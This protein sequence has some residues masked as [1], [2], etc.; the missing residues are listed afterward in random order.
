MVESQNVEWKRSWKDK[1][2]EWVCGF[3]NAQGGTI[4]IG[5]D[6]DGAVHALAD[7]KRLLAEIP[8]KIRNLLGLTIDV[9]LRGSEQGD[10]LEIVVPAQSVPV[11]YR[12][13][14]YYVVP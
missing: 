5:K 11:S 1:Y 4:Y 2:L 3:S 14:Y 7:S 13:H 12:G 6:D 9:N 8:Q 10:F